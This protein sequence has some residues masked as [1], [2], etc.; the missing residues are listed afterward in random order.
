MNERQPLRRSEIEMSTTR[1]PAHASA[2]DI[3]RVV[4][5]ARAAR[6]QTIRAAAIE[7]NAAVKRFFAGFHRPSPRKSAAV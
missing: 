2:A 5:A 4:A 1:I 6:A 3:N 7:F